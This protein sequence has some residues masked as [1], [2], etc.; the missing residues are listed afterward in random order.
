MRKKN[1]FE[2]HYLFLLG[3]LCSKY[4][5][6]LKILGSSHGP[7]AHHLLKAKLHLPSPNDPRGISKY[8]LRP[9]SAP[10]EGI[11]ILP[12]LC[13]KPQGFPSAFLTTGISSCPSGGAAYLVLGAA[14]HSLSGRVQARAS[15]TGRA[16]GGL[17]PPWR[18]RRLKGHQGVRKE[19]SA[20]T[21]VKV[22]L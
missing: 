19:G 20:V 8:N 11:Q 6:V 22:F 4:I 13:T 15:T 16:L 3:K 18:A 12:M 5:T 21:H 14:P 9:S 7:A 10:S 2:N 1:I 17:T